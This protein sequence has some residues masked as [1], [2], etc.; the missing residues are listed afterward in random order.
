[1][2]CIS[3]GKYQKKIIF[4]ILSILLLYLIY[5]L[6]YFSGYFYNFK[7]I[8]T[9]NLYS[10][11]F[12]F[13]FLGSSLFGGI[14]FFILVKNI[15][16]NSKQIIPTKKKD[17]GD[18]KEEE[19]GK[20]KISLDLL[21]DK[22]GKNIRIPIKYLIISA[23]LELITNFAFR[24]IVF[25]FMD[26][27]SKILYGGFEIIFIKLIN[28]Y[29]Y[30]YKLYKHQIISMIILLVV[31]FI[32]IMFREIFLMKIVRNEYTFYKN[33]FEY[34]IKVISNIKIEA[35]IIYYFYLGFIILGLISKSILVCFDKWLITDKLCD[36]YKLLYFKGLFGFIPAL[37]IQLSLFFVLGES[38][39]I[40]EEIINVRNLYK[41]L[42]FPLSSFTL[43]KKI[44]IILIIL[45][46]IFVGLFYTVNI[47]T[48]NEY[49]PEYIGFASVISSTISI[50]TIQFINAIFNG[51]G[52][53]Q[54]IIIF[55]LIHFLFF[56]LI[57]IPSLIICEIIIL[58]FCNCDKNVCSNIE[59]RAYSEVIA[60]LRIYDEDG[61][62][63]KSSMISSEDKSSSQ[64][65]S[66]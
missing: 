43:N 9:P 47:M 66:I 51:N 30:K 16:N 38:G 42:S 63:T 36:P 23:F 17:E 24:S 58:H 20:R 27:E 18:Q 5:Q 34:Y 8:N 2:S 59:K 48:I 6:E 49:S 12:S 37:A 28:R 46:F 41:R 45:F 60:S 14:F 3:I 65:N 25:D 33:N 32:A 55:C 54:S 53:N 21:Y 15:R 64:V 29:I 7:K 40:N 35:G 62:E 22:D 11:Y 50:V 39:N 26:I 4:P 19:T 61:D 10:L 57:L 1:M 52:N 44:N 56:I 31:L 13:S